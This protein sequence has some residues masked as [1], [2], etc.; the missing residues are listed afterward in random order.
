MIWA[1]FHIHSQFSDGYMSIPQIVD[2]YGRQGFKAIAITDHICERKTILGKAAHYMDKTLTPE[3]FPRYMSQLNEESSRA[4]EQYGMVLIPGFEI[5]KNSL[6]NH[7][8]AHLLGLGVSQWVSA[9]QEIDLIIKEIKAQGALCI[10]AHPVP[11]NK[12]E[13]Q[14]LHLWDRRDELAEDI[15]AWEVA[16][17]SYFFKEVSQSGLAMLANSDLHHPRQMNSWKTVLDCKAEPESILNAIRQQNLSFKFY[18]QPTP[19]KSLQVSLPRQSWL[20]GT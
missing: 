12:L 14:T 5:T 13:L 7:R 1:D 15:D 9:D 16:S 6:N 4:W 18:Q 10:A 8:S 19:A 3:S 17:G 11:T 20:F 2:F